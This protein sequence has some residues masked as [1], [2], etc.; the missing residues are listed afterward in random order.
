[1]LDTWAP[2]GITSLKHM[3][4]P[5]KHTW[6]PGCTVY[7]FVLLWPWH[8]IYVLDLQNM[9]PSDEASLSTLFLNKISQR[10]TPFWKFLFGLKG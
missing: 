9:L 3:N 6:A 4:G 10:D 2:G 8:L 7:H 1:M 5:L